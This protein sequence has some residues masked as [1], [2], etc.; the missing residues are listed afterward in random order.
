M[1]GPEFH[2]QCI[3]NSKKGKYCTVV[4][5]VLGMMHARNHSSWEVW[6]H[7]KKKKEGRMRVGEGWREETII[8]Y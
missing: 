3:K 5:T 8:K 7:K 6:A 1:H 2:P 4:N